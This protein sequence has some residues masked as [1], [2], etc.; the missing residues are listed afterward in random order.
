MKT[1]IYTLSDLEGI[2][3]VGK[4]NHPEKRLKIH[5]KESRKKRTRKE[6]W[7]YNLLQK[8]EIPKMEIID[9]VNQSEWSFFESY[10]IYQLKSWGFNL[11]NGTEG[12]EGSDG[13]RGKNHSLETIVKL[14]KISQGKNFSKETREKISDANRKRIVSD[15]TKKKI[16]EKAKNRSIPHSDEIKT[17]ISER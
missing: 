16:S 15:D 3:Y 12:G 4:S 10:W 14:K 13:F 9:C 11:V 2:K 7:I 1:Y 8:G 6:K 5:L 17:K